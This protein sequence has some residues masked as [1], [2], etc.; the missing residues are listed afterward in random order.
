MK[1]ACIMMQKN[2]RELLDA[3]IQYHGFLFGYEN[4]YIFDNGSDDDVQTKLKN[5]IEKGV[6]V[7]FQF[8]KKE[9]FESKGEIF[10]K[11]IK[12]LD[13]KDNYDF[14]FPLD[15]DEFLATINKNGFISCEIEDVVSELSENIHRNEAFC[16]QYQLFNSGFRKNFFGKVYTKKYFFLKNT[17]KFLDKGF[18]CGESVYGGSFKTNIVYFHFHNKPFILLLESAK[19]KLKDRVD[20]NN[21]AVLQNYNGDGHHLKQYFLMTEREYVDSFVTSHQETIMCFGETLNKM[22]IKYP[23]DDYFKDLPLNIGC[24][25][26]IGY[27]DLVDIW[28]NKISISG[29]CKDNVVADYELQIHDQI[30]KPSSVQ[31]YERLDVKEI[32]PHF[33]LKTGFILDFEL[34]GVSLNSSEVVLFVVT[35]L[36]KLWFKD[37][38]K[39]QDKINEFMKNV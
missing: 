19:E 16:I 22:N 27:I 8:S 15:C 3:W 9:D 39:L 5:Y 30:I 26:A 11:T 1:I 14:Y 38:Q 37:S 12:T 13:E 23:F 24:G 33:D 20:V 32:H 21:L 25:R 34:S 36:G 31:K 28:G 18:H 29:W 10:L 7:S 35:G 6:N 2:E 17:I 4:L